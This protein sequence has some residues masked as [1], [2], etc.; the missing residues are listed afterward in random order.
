MDGLHLKKKNAMKKITT[1]VVIMLIKT[2][3]IAQLNAQLFIKTVKSGNWSDS[4][5]W[6]TGTVPTPNDNVLILDSNQVTMDNNV[7]SCNGLSLDYGTKLIAYNSGSITVNGDWTNLGTF[8]DNSSTVYFSGLSGQ[9][10]GGKGTT[11]STLVINDV[12]SVS[13]WGDVAIKGELQLNAGKLVTNGMNLTLLS[14]ANGTARIAPVNTALSTISG[15]VTVQ[16]YINNMQSGWRFLGSAVIGDT[17]GDLNNSFKTYG[18]T[19]ATVPTYSFSSVRYYDETAPGVSS[20]GYTDIKNSNQLLNNGTGYICWIDSGSYVTSVTGQPAIG[21]QNLNITY[22][23]T[24]DTINDGWNLIAN[25]YASSIDWN[26]SNWNKTGIDNAIYVWNPNLQQYATYK[27]GIGTN[28]GSNII[29]SS[30]AFWVHVNQSNSSLTC[31]ENVKITD[32]GSFMKTSNQVNPLSTIKFILSNA[33]YSDETVLNFTPTGLSGYDKSEDVIKLFSSNSKIPNISSIANEKYDLAINTLPS[34]VVNQTIPIRVKVGISGTYSIKP[35]VNMFIKQFSSM[36]LEDLVTKIKTD[37]TNG[38][39]YSFTITDTT[40]TPRFLLHLT[41]PVLTPPNTL[42]TFAIAPSCSYKSDGKGIVKTHKSTGSVTYTWRAVSGNTLAVH[43]SNFDTDTLSGLGSG[44]YIVS[45]L[46]NGNKNNHNKALSD[47]VFITSEPMIIT[48]KISH[49]DNDNS[50]SGSIDAEVLKGGKSPY[51]FY[52]SNNE[53]STNIK[54]LSSGSYTLYTIDANGCVDTSVHVV[55]K[56]G[57]LASAMERRMGQDKSQS[58][59][60]P[61]KI[62]F[63]V[64]PNPNSGEFTVDIS[65]LENNHDVRITLRDEKGSNVYESFFNVQDE[66]SIQRKIVPESRLTNGLYFCTLMVEGVEQTVK[67]VIN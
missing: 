5:I 46:E 23:S 1:I 21:D 64:F 55:N 63:T 48:S 47:T 15:N 3:S 27:D 6:S 20:L 53:V 24:L 61:G 50:L 38:Q 9:I 42:K 35:Y 59:Y 8:V 19:G 44:K 67:V 10:I 43:T 7:I 65:G 41:S 32:G 45:V 4:S 33:N 58:A 11:F 36:I 16:R 62:K 2:L 49:N 14:D 34:T 31:A 66:S 18:Y 57:A 12:N 28:G 29:P 51:K 22:T 37:I 25:P 52:W 56:N 60:G 17:V 30:Q 54:N 39:L 40:S 13:L 26:S